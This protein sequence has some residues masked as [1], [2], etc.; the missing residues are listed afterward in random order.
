MR[1]CFASSV[2][3]NLALCNLSMALTNPFLTLSQMDLI[4]LGAKYSPCM[5]VDAN[6]K[7][8][9]DADRA[10]EKGSACCV[11]NDGS[12]CV[13]RVQSQCVSYNLLF[14]FF[15]FMLYCS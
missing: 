10:E 15:S 11:R 2:F 7:K 9:L 3:T 4:H 1:Q 5:R 8:S 12:G 6:L 14:H 13:Q